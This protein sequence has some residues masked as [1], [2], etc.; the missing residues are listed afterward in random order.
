M[1]VASTLVAQAAASG[2]RTDV[3]S[4]A[5]AVRDAESKVIGCRGLQIPS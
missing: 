1:Y 3:Y 2:G 5:E 4:P